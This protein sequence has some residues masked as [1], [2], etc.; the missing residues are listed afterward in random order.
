MSDSGQYVS[1]RDEHHEPLD[2]GKL[3]AAGCPEGLV[4][5]VAES[6]AAVGVT[7]EQVL[8]WAGEYG[9][10]TFEAVRQFARALRAGGAKGGE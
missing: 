4:D 1:Q 6:A 2:K 7:P 8:R 3:R 5:E 9:P 10:G